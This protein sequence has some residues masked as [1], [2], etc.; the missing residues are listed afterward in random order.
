MK[1]APL[2]I[3]EKDFSPV[4]RAKARRH[5]GAKIFKGIIPPFTAQRREGTKAQRIFLAFTAQRR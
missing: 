4:Y 5:E 1:K 3:L 2:T